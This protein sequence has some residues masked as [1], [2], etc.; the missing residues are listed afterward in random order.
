MKIVPPQVIAAAFA[1]V[2]GQ[3]IGLDSKYM[4]EIPDKP[5]AHGI[6]T[7]AFG[8]AF[9]DRGLWLA[10]FTTVLTL[11]M[12]DGVESLATIA[13]IDKIDPFKRKSDPNKT[14]FAMGVSNMCSSLAGGLTIIPGGVKST[15]CIVGGGRTQWANFYNACFLVLYILVGRNVINMMPLSALGAIVLFTGYKLCAP[16]VWKHMAHIGGEQLFVFTATVLATL[17]TDLLWGIAV[18]ILV[19]LALEAWVEIRLQHVEEGETLFGRV[20]RQLR[21]TGDLFRNPV[22]QAVTTPDGYHLYFARPLVCFNT[23]HLNHALDQIPS[24]VGAVYFHITGMVTLVDHTATTTLFDFIEEFKRS[25]RGVAEILGLE[26]LRPRS[27]DLTCMRTAAPILAGERAKALQAMSSLSL[28]KVS[29]EPRKVVEELDR[30][31]LSISGRPMEDPFDHPITA[32]VVSGSG[33]LASKAKASWSAA[34]E[35]WQSVETRHGDRGLD[36]M[37]LSSA[38]RTVYNS[39]STLEHWGIMATETAPR[40]YESRNAVM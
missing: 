15:A 31:S 35:G 8:A 4:I 33:V 3:L 38:T 29:D 36:G 28:T 20:A 1:L 7:P 30:L 12:I 22:A 32:F 19:K 14:L 17:T 24:G 5:F 21:L 10:M 6:V 23:L 2:V 27:H 40:R 26:R 25:G 11:T 39:T 18:G 34:R 13:A 37:S 9:S 16:K